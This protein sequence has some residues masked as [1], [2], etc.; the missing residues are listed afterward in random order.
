MTIASL[1]QWVELNQDVPNGSVQLGGRAV[2]L[3]HLQLTKN[4]PEPGY[5]LE[6]FQ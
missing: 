6:V 5:T 4:Q 3:D 2:V 1:F